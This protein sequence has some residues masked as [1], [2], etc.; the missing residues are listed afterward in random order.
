LFNENKEFL[1]LLNHYNNNENKV[2]SNEKEE[3]KNN[4]S[5]GDY[6][7]IDNIDFTKFNIP[8][9]LSCDGIIKPNVVFFGENVE[10]E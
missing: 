10:L 8:N 7:L 9:C 2:N 6:Y 3:N 5:D 4:R 1:E